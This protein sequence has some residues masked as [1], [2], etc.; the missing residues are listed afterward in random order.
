M[1][2]FNK[3]STYSLYY[4]YLQKTLNRLNIYVNVDGMLYCSSRM[5][6]TFGLHDKDT[7]L[8]GQPETYQVLNTQTV[9]YGVINSHV[10]NPTKTLWFGLFPILV[11]P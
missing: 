2:T 6:V 4:N 10:I 1:C 11:G 3:F 5:T 7:K 9:S 8:E